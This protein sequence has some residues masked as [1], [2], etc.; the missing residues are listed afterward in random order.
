MKKF[1]V[2]V[3]LVLLAVA[4]TG[5]AVTCAYDNVPAAT[6]LVPYWKVSLN[7]A[8]GFP[9]PSGGTDTLISIVNVSVPGV[10]AHVTV[11]N[12]YSKAVIDFNLPLTGKD[13]V[14]F[15]M[16][17]IMN[18]KLSPNLPQY[19]TSKYPV[20]PCGITDPGLPTVGYSPTVGFG[21]TQFIRF[22]HPDS[23][24]LGID[25]ITSVSQY[26]LGG[27][28]DAIGPG[29]RTTVWNSLDE[30]GD[31]T[32][33]TNSKG[34]NIL[35]LDNPACAWG[36]TATLKDAL[37]GYLTID[38]VNYCTNF[39]P[40]Q[41]DFYN[42]DAIA[43]AGWTQSA[44]PDFPCTAA[45]PCAVTYT[46]N[47][48]IGDVF[49][50][51]SATQGGNVS[52][53]PAVAVEFDSRLV[54]TGTNLVPTTKTFFGKFVSATTFTQC[55]AETTTTTGCTSFINT[56][57]APFQFP[58]DGREPLGDRYGFRYLADQ[59]NGLQSWAIV[60]RSDY[61]QGTAVNLCAWANPGSTA[62]KGAAGSGLYD[63]AHQVQVLTYDN[64]ENLFGG[65]G[66]PPG[67]SGQL[68]GSQSP[69]Y[70]F[71]ESQRINL[72]TATDWNPA[73]FKGGWVDLTLAGP[74]LTGATRATGLYNMGWV[75]VQ[76][77][78]P[79]AFISVGHAAAN[80]NNQFL[81]SPN[82]LN[83]TEVNFQQFFTPFP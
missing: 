76:H 67:P 15:S 11:W 35:D 43:T 83:G 39:F 79:G 29:F 54:Y 3:A 13:V 55:A 56:Y 74:G 16:R 64:D 6:L 69:N 18:G 52:G 27:V 33:F 14:S 38:V 78:A 81:C 53:D 82:R 40:D 61:Y 31:I 30:S 21:Q 65:I 17:D 1:S 22:S 20:D 58:G 9:V 34:G 8:T 80:L 2:I 77:T 37:S 60:W 75:G 36:T 25:V 23:A 70:I 59:A 45:A 12:K 42:K 68:P 46:P 48:L 72:L 32:T 41:S 49:Y 62:N 73:N 71:L 57:A 19:D 51:D 24:T 50:V 28:V 63:V 26:N 47:V 66:V 10:I 7:G 4:G 44:Y 5:Y